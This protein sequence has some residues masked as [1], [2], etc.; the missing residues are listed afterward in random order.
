MSKQTNAD[1]PQPGNLT[2]LHEKLGQA[3][4]GAM[5]ADTPEAIASVFEV[6]SRVIN[7][8]RHWDQ[9]VYV[10]GNS[11][12]EKWFRRIKE[13]IAPSVE[14]EKDSVAASRGT[15]WVLARRMT[16][17]DKRELARCM[18]ELYHHVGRVGADD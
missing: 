7:D 18:S 11:E 2:Y 8:Y 10:K 3:I 16:R 5:F 13:L 1:P 15:F 14:D 17:D 12:A 4:D 6:L 9:S